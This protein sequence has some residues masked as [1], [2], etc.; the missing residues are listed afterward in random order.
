MLAGAITDWYL[1]D[2]DSTFA[3]KSIRETTETHV[4][5]AFGPSEESRS[6]IY[7]KRWSAVKPIGKDREWLRWLLISVE[8]IQI[9]LG[10][11]LSVAFERIL[12]L[13]IKRCSPVQCAAEM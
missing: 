5:N 8:N 2:I 6:T 4:R 11:K 3:M 9:R 7:A 10:S 1:V 12:A 13:N